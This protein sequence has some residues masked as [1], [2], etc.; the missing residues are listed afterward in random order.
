MPSSPKLNVQLGT[1]FLG[2]K[3]VYIRKMLDHGLL[4]SS[5]FYLMYVQ[6]EEYSE[7]FIDALDI[8]FENIGKI[9]ERSRITEKTGNNRKRSGFAR[10]T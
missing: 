5:A 1:D 6:K 8:V 7:K 3:A 2:V 4:V 10:L 9:I